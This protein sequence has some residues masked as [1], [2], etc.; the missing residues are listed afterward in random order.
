MIRVSRG[1]LPM[2]LALTCTVVQ[3]QTAPGAPTTR[4]QML[5][6]THCIACHTAQV[7]WR[8]KKQVT[9]WASLKALVRTWQATAGQFWNEDDIVQVA[10]YL[11]DAYYHFAQTSDVVAWRAPTAR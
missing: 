7:H 4:A 1:L 3:A 8:D 9:D 11:N 10:R 5:Y 6:D 2:V